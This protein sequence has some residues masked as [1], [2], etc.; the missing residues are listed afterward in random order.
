MASPA[1]ST[2]R[3]SILM[4][5]SISTALGLFL[6]ATAFAADLDGSLAKQSIND[7]V[8]SEALKVKLDIAKV[9][10]IAK[11][12][13][14]VIIGNPSILDATIQDGRTI[15]LTGRSYGVTNLIILD[16][17]GEPIV[18]ETVVVEGQ[19]FKSV[20][21]YRRAVRETLACDPVCEPTVTIGDSNEAFGQLT[22]QI[23]Q[24]SSSASD[25]AN[26]N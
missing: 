2:F 17:D 11:T 21:I 13:D 24:R 15:V 10:R 18:D 14:T 9:V 19:S 26:S 4:R 12:A 1:L 25:A 3:K 7:N 16:S 5:F 23:A 6:G 8:Q 22:G 20:R